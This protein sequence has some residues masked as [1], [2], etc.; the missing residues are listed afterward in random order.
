MSDLEQ[1]SV[2]LGGIMDDLD[3]II[4]ALPA[5]QHLSTLIDTSPTIM[6]SSSRRPTS[7]KPPPKSRALTRTQAAQL[8]EAGPVLGNVISQGRNWIKEYVWTAGRLEVGVSMR[9]VRA[10]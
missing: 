2:E 7:N 4:E 8:L 6:P 9:K 3:L 5:A 10:P 1:L